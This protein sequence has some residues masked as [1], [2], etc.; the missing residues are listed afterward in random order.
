[1]EK[2]ELNVS[3]YKSGTG[4]TSS[5]ISLPKKWM[6]QLGIDPENK[7][8]EVIFDEEEQKIIIYKKK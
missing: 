8:V 2:R 3:F 7:M 1:M 5:R 4:G 6:D